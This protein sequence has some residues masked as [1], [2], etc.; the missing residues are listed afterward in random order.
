MN[1][2]E[3]TKKL[4]SLPSYDDGNLYE[5]P[6]SDFLVSYV[7]TRLPWLKVTQQEVAPNRFNV[8]LQDE[9]QTRLLIVDQ[10]DTVVPD[11]GWTTNP[12]EAIEREG[13]IFG[14]GASDSKGNVAALLKA[15]EEIGLTNGLAVLFYV[16]EEYF[17][18]GMNQFVGSSL[19]HSID[20]SWILSVDGNGS[21]LGTGCRGLVE[22]DLELRSASGHSANPQTSGVL[23]P[24]LKTLGSFE[25]RLTSYKDDQQ[26]IPTCNV[27]RLQSGLLQREDAVRPDFGE[28]G[29]RIPNFLQA[30]IEVRTTPSLSGKEIELFWR[31]SLEGS[32]GLDVSIAPVFDYAGFSTPRSELMKVE[33]AIASVLGRVDSLDAST[34]GYLDLSMLAQVY[35]NARLCSFGI[36][37]PGTNHRANEYVLCQRLEE[38]QTIYQQIIQ[39]LLMI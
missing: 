25:E 30:K 37:E 3:L 39:N 33:Q 10:I 16:D 5:K 9:G 21:S 7:Q 2:I 14:L 24:F 6:M 31:S 8:F 38:G 36:G 32:I 18:K 29:N 27:A 11:A 28:Q 4:I 13:K 26:G 15:L 23:R 20:P 12:L 34:F 35:T 1:V 22:F 19:A 17:F